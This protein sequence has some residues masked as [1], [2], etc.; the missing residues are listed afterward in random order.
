GDNGASAKIHV[1]VLERIANGSED[2]APGN[3]PFGATIVPT[4]S[5]DPLGDRFA[6][7]RADAVKAIFAAA[8]AGR[9]DLLGAR[10]SSIRVANPSYWV[11]LVSG[12]GLIAGPLLG[13]VFSRSW[14]WVALGFV[15]PVVGLLVAWALAWYADVTMDATFSG[16][17]HGVRPKLRDAFRRA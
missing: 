17:W 15:T 9:E 13:A 7:R 10:P 14:A 6:R 16:F 2:Y 8:G 11:S 1:S 12:L 3:L 4:M 5:G